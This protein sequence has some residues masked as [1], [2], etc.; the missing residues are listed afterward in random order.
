V[1]K[2]PVDMELPSIITPADNYVG[3]G[4]GGGSSSGGAADANRTEKDSDAI[5]LFVGQVPKNF[6]DKDLRPYLEPYGEIF[7]LSILRD[8]LN[9]AHK[10]S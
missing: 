1:G 2:L 9:L 3:G 4:G 6:E 5:K 10:G 7:D 8:K